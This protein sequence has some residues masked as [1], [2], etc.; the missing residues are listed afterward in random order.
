MFDVDFVGEL[1]GPRGKAYYSGRSRVN[2]DFASRC[3]SLIAFWYPV[4]G[5]LRMIEYI[6][7]QTGHLLV[8][9]DRFGYS[10]ASLIR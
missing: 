8:D 3:F 1:S 4:F 5:E 7:R 2:C 6:E 9:A 10:G